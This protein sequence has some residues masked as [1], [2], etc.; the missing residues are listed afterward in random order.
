MQI[1]DASGFGGPGGADSSITPVPNG[2]L[3][4]HKLLYLTAKMLQPSEGWLKRVKAAHPGLE[5]VLEEQDTFRNQ[6]TNPHLDW[7]NITIMLTGAVLP[8]PEQA[9]KLQLVQ[10]GSCILNTQPGNPRREG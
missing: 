6:E 5:I 4:G 7:D 8:T 9:P 2:A 1:Q 10:V 3:D